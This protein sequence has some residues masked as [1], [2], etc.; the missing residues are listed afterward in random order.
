[1]PGQGEVVKIK[2]YFHNKKSIFNSHLVPHFLS[3]FTFLVRY[4]TGTGPTRIN[5]MK[6]TRRTKIEE[7]VY[8]Y[9][10][11]VVVSNPINNQTREIETD[12]GWYG[13]TRYRNR[14]YCTYILLHFFGIKNKI[15]LLL[16]TSR[17]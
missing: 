9:Q 13:T 8:P 7:K 4:R 2:P 16:Q 15:S 12:D 11:I 10:F 5:T 17:L 3:M 1:M 6:K 14:L